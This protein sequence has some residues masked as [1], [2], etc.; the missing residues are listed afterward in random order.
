MNRY[1]FLSSLLPPLILGEKPEL[2]FHEFVV[3]CKENLDDD[4]MEQLRVIRR[5]MDI[6]NLRAFWRKRQL[7][8][9]GNYNAKELEEILTVEDQFPDYVF[10]FLHEYDTEEERLKHFSKLVSLFFQNEMENAEG[11][12]KRYLVFER[13]LRLILL[14]FRAKV[15]KRDVAVELQYEDPTDVLVA[16][17]LAQKDSEIYEPPSEYEHLKGLFLENVDN[18]LQLYEEI[19]KYRLNTLLNMEDGDVFR[20]DHILC[21]LSQLII[22]DGWLKHNQDKGKEIV[23]TILK[24]KE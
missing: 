8:S 23:D 24:D 16:Q 5:Y 14:G 11:F 1:Y 7:D 20:L 21:Y 13:D 15:L 12:L 6:Q 9:H 18:P 22:V 10:D 4:D 2:P 3:H 19:S 17:I